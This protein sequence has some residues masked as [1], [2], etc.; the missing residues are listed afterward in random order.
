MTIKEL[1]IRMNEKL[2]S[3]Y[4]RTGNHMSLSIG[5]T[6]LFYILYQIILEDIEKK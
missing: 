1:N 3:I 5:N 4:K 6:D 2:S